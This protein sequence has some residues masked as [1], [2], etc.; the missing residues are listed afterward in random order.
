MNAPSFTAHATEA[1]RFFTLA[2]AKGR[3]AGSVTVHPGRVT[4]YTINVCDV[5]ITASAASVTW[6]KGRASRSMRQTTDKHTALALAGIAAVN[7]LTSNA[8]A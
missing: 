8:T 5:S 4:T 6:V 1:G 7:N 2:D 3:P